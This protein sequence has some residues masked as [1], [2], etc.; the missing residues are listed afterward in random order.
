MRDCE[1]VRDEASI[2]S[3]M[4]CFPVVEAIDHEYKQGELEVVGG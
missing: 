3:H 4:C 1:G 2:L